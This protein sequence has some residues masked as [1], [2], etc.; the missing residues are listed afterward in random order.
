MTADDRLAF[1]DLASE[2]T[3]TRFA[4][5]PLFE[6][7]GDGLQPVALEA[8]CRRF[9]GLPLAEPERFFDAVRRR[10]LEDQVDR[11]CVSE[12]LQAAVDLGSPPVAINVHAATL[13]DPDFVAFLGAAADQLEVPLDRI[14]LEILEHP[15]G[16]ADRLARLQ[17]ESLRRRGLRVAL[18]DVGRSSCYLPRLLEYRPDLIKIGRE[19]VHGCDRDLRRVDILDSLVR[20]AAKFSARVVAEGVETDGE[21]QTLRALGVELVQGFHCAPPLSADDLRLHALM[22]PVLTPAAATAAAR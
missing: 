8:R 16:P 7:A 14:T 3:A 13:E 21:L 2:A 5:Q 12:A 20:L 19:L 15:S 10:G 11:V 22:P 9:A 17:L 6:L 4:F 1:G 18:D